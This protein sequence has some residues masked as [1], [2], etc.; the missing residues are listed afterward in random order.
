[1]SL[2]IKTK[3]GF[4]CV[5][6]GRTTWLSMFM[7]R[8]KAERSVITTL[9]QWNIF[10]EWIM[11]AS[12]GL[13]RKPPPRQQYQVTPHHYS[14]QHTSRRSLPRTVLTLHVLPLCL[15]S[16]GTGFD[17]QGSASNP[18]PSEYDVSPFGS[19]PEWCMSIL[20]WG[21]VSEGQQLGPPV[22]P[23]ATEFWGGKHMGH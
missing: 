13:L 8:S 18:S 22:S 20:D 17:E 11:G 10:H 5:A 15:I 14:E 21:K 7:I 1:M 6:S 9:L 23:L 12:W 19:L 4:D 2:E 16:T 3:W